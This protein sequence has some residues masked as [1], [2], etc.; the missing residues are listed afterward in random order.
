MSQTVDRTVEDIDKARRP[1]SF[2]SAGA[3][4]LDRPRAGHRSR[5]VWAR[6]VAVT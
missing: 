1:W 5:E 3:G 2:G 6:L 4:G